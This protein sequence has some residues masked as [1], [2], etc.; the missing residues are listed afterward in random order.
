MR[1]LTGLL[2]ALAAIFTLVEV[3]EAR[4][5]VRERVQYYNI[6]GKTGAQIMRSISRRGPRG[7]GARHA[8][9]TT[10]IS[11]RLDLKPVVRGRRCVYA[12]TTVY[13]DLTYRYPRWRNQRGASSRVR[14]AW[15]RF[16]GRVV[17]HE[18][19]HGA[20]ARKYAA[21]IDREFKRT[22]RSVRNGCRDSG[23][24][25]ARRFQALVRQHDRE[26][27]RFDRRESR[28]SARVRRLE[29]ALRGS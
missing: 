18:K 25:Q 20:I 23:N 21:R 17:A 8:I 3:A 5:I 19:Q 9:A 1:L 16:Y 7:T 14:S 12:S 26:H 13:L 27:A 11:M 15:K 4:V 29:R 28:A 10:Q 2:V 22:R 24:R 6:T